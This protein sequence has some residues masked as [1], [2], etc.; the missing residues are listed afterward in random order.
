MSTATTMTSVG[1]VPESLTGRA[2]C[3]P[4]VIGSGD[5]C[6]RLASPL[7]AVLLAS[8]SDRRDGDDA[9]SILEDHLLR[10]W[11][12]TVSTGFSPDLFAGESVNSAA[13]KAKWTSNDAR[14]LQNFYVDNCKRFSGVVGG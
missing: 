8:V 3:G 2:T 6:R 7:I 9:Q 14:K 13:D 5:E 1:L 11:D 12:E 4:S 10:V